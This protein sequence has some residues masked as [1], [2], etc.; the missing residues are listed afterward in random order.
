MQWET[1]TQEKLDRMIAAIPVFHRRITQEVVTLRAVDLARKRGA[2]QV[3]EA[4]VVGAFFMTCH[5]LF[6]V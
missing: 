2:Q 5:R 1:A 3:E 6:T 4:D